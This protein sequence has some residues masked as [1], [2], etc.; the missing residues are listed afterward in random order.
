MTS[1]VIQSLLESKVVDEAFYY[2]SP[3]STHLSAWTF[4]QLTNKFIERVETKRCVFSKT[5]SNLPVRMFVARLS[6][7][8][9]VTLQ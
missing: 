9:T 4:K 6:T 3:T 7:R 1:P 5:Q 2:L 8:T